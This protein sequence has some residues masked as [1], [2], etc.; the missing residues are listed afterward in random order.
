M[1]KTFGR[2][3]RENAEASPDKSARG[4]SGAWSIVVSAPG[5]M[6]GR[7]REY[8]LTAK[9]RY[10][11]KT[12]SADDLAEL[13]KVV[14]DAGGPSTKEP[15]EAVRGTLMWRWPPSADAPEPLEPD[16]SPGARGGETLLLDNETPPHLM[17]DKPGRNDPCVCGSGKKYKKC[18][19]DKPRVIGAC[20]VPTGERGTGRPCG[21]TAVMAVFCKKC[22]KQYP[23]CSDESHK[24]TAQQMMNGHILRV[25]PEEIPVSIF[26]AMVADRQWLELHEA[27]R[28]QHPELWARLFEYIDERRQRRAP[29]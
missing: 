19:I 26:D 17:T 4:A 20:L 9:N 23:S 16:A 24:K 2:Q 29:N 8:W 12:P 15:E 1:N 6:N 14:F 11:A 5:F 27:Q 13:R 7:I 3:L 22:G 25:H 10:P 21:E 18:C 28:A